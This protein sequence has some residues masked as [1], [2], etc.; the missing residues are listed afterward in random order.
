MTN[1]KLTR[2]RFIRAGAAGLGAGLMGCDG[3]AQGPAGRSVLELA[4]HVTYHTQRLLLGANRLAPE[5]SES[6]ISPNFKANGTSD[7]PDEAYKALATNNFV[8]WRLRVDGLVTNPLN[9]SLPDLRAFPALT[10]ITRHDCVEGWSCI[11]KW[12]GSPL[13]EV[14][15]LAGTRSQARFVVFYCADTMEGGEAVGE[16]KTRAT[17]DNEPIR[18]YESLDLIDALHPQTILAYEMNGEPLPVAHGAP[19][20]LRVERQLGYKMAKYLTRIE[21]VDSY[22]AI[23]GGRGGYWEDRG[24]DWY[25]G[26]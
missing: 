25:A 2:R 19:L 7:P 12:T 1:A 3:A 9:L 11:G 22:A 18:Y 14:L 26:I 5:F 8:G 6:D 13:S 20:R 23:G 17:L 15:A 10:Q 4:E 21:L 24:Y 16:T